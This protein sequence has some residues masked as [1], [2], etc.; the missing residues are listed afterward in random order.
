MFLDYLK[1]CKDDSERQSRL[2]ERQQLENIKRLL[3]LQEERDAIML[4]IMGRILNEESLK[5]RR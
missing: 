3:E 2:L 5:S 1:L 4:R